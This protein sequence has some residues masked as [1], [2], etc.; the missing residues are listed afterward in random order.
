MKNL[1]CLADGN[2]ILFKLN[3]KRNSFNEDDS[4]CNEAAQYILN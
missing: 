4:S 2:T 3:I 1:Y